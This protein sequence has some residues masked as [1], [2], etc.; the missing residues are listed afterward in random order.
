MSEAHAGLEIQNGAMSPAVLCRRIVAFCHLVFE[1]PRMSEARRILLLGVVA[2]VLV[3]CG[4]SEED[5]TAEP[6]FTQQAPAAAGKEYAFAIHPLHN[7][8]RMFEIYG[9]LID[10]LNRNIQ[11]ASFRLEASR[12]YE[13]FEKKLY[14]RELEFALPNPYQTLISLSHGYHVIAKMGDDYKFTGVVLVRRDSGIKNLSDLKGKKVSYPASTALAAAMMPQYY[15]QSHGL[16]VNRDIENIYV[17]SQESSIMNVYLGNVAAGVT[18]PL[19]WE[20]FQKEH[21]DKASELELKWETEPLINNGVVAR[22]DLPEQLVKRVAQLLD[23]LHTS[24][25]GKKILARMPLS[26]F[27]LADDRRYR[28][29]DDFLKKFSQTVRPLDNQ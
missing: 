1:P 29:I 11:G 26:R 4:Q 9:P 28:V 7:P 18:W 27:E 13:A 12:N 3:G 20:A 2:L 14:A 16:D 8:V 5:K 23:T 15:F 25:E 10:Y 19:P 6:K 17:G 22:D 24:E 21:P